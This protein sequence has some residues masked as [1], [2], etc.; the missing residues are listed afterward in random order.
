MAINF[1]VFL[2]KLWSSSFVQLIIQ[3]LFLITATVLKFT[4][5]TVLTPLNFD[6]S[7]PLALL[8]YSFHSFSSILQSFAPSTSRSRKC[9]YPVFNVFL[10]FF[11]C[12]VVSFLY[13][14][15]IPTLTD[16]E[17]HANTF[18][19]FLFHQFFASD[20]NIFILGGRLSTRL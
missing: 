5:V 17:F 20:G 8:R 10:L 7:I 18:L 9:L 19:I 12:V 3:A 1:L 11:D 13:C 2:S 16:A 15:C 6:L 4:A 14:T